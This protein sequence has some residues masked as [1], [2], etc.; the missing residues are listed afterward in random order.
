M[1]HLKLYN[2]HVTCYLKLLWH[3]Y[4]LTNILLPGNIFYEQ[5]S[6]ESWSIELASLQVEISDMLAFNCLRLLYSQ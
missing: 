5:C 4:A 1:W 3:A 6:N 2:V